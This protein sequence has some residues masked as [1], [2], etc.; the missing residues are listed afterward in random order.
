MTAVCT[1]KIDSPNNSRILSDH[2][3]D[4]QNY[5]ADHN[6]NPTIALDRRGTYSRKLF[7]KIPL[8][9]WW[10]SIFFV[11]FL[12]QVLILGALATPRWVKQGDEP[13]RWKGGLIKCGSC[14]GRWEG[15]YY[16]AI[17]NK[18]CDDDMDG[19]CDTFSMLLKAG[20]ATAVF[21][22][23]ALLFLN[24]WEMLIFVEL[25]GIFV[26][27]DWIVYFIVA[28]AFISNTFAIAIWFG[29]TGATFND[30]CHKASSI[31]SHEKVCAT[32]GPILM[33]VTEIW[34]PITCIFFYWVYNKR[35]TIVPT[36][37]ASEATTG[38][39]R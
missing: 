26:L 9:Y 16:M 4:K 39:L 33:I 28:A 37:S 12:N 11:I 2:E 21:E 19:Y 24:I 5:F 20:I 15:E 31:K 6:M 7:H 18:A 23:L 38:I 3:E 35:W 30:D 1:P 13:N 14:N 32:D 22:I 8:K 17:S 29:V 25:R 36:E 27:K 34:I 10:Y